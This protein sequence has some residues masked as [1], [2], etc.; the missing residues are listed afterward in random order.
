MKS[1]KEKYI[2][3]LKIVSGILIVLIFVLTLV[4]VDFISKKYVS[5][6]YKR[7]YVEVVSTYDDFL[8][9]KDVDGDSKYTIKTKDKYKVGDIVYVTYYKDIENPKAIELV[10][11]KETKEDTTEVSIPVEETTTKVV[12]E[13]TTKATT[14]K[15]VETKNE[16]KNTTKNATNENVDSIVLNYVESVKTKLDNYSA[17]ESN[18]Q[19]AKEYFCNIVDFIF[20]GG[21][22]KGHTFDE[23]SSSAK[24]KVVYYALIIDSK[25]DNKFPGYKDTLSDKY[26]DIKAKLIGKYIQVVEYV[27]TNEPELYEGLK[28]DFLLLKKSVGL[29]WNVVSSALKY[30][31]GNIVSLAKEWYENFRG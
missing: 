16:D 24:A 23:L 10:M 25:I 11:S 7:A 5:D 30:V 14:K 21:E 6:N 20:Y 8:L 27:K 1:V 15:Q 17:N 18:K 13:V 31:G 12:E 29:T 26:S 9:A 28:R 4:L 22:I 3:D 19:T 2:R